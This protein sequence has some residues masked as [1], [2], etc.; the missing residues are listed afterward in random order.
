METS[1]KSVEPNTLE[2]QQALDVVQTLA[3]SAKRV[4]DELDTLIQQKLLHDPDLTVQGKKRVSRRAWLRHS[5]QLQRLYISLRTT[6]Q[7][8]AV[9]FSAISVSNLYSLYQQTSQL[10]H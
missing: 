8:L 9:S 6:R 2:L 4:L 5:K 3:A 10:S 1:I 7:N